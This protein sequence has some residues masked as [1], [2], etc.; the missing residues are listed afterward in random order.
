MRK[1]LTW[2]PL[3]RSGAYISKKDYDVTREFILS[4][5]CEEMTLLDLIELG[6]R[7]LAPMIEDN[8]AWHILVVK[9]DLEAR[10]I[11]VSFQKFAP[12]RVQ[13]LRLRRKGVKKFIEHNIASTI[14]QQTSKSG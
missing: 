2:H 13:F 14:N 9:L 1:I 3:G 6:E 4:A 8:I 10:G 12:H 11:I 7:L 5:L